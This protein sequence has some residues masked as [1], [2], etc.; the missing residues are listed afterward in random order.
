MHREALVLLK[1]IIMILIQ[2]N[3]GYKLTE[4][5]NIKANPSTEWPTISYFLTQQLFLHSFPLSQT[6]HLLLG[7][8]SH[9]HKI[10]TTPKLLFR[11]AKVLGSLTVCYQSSLCLYSYVV[12]SYKKAWQQMPQKLYLG[13]KDSHNKDPVHQS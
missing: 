1:E 6:N 10:I 5:E 13:D 8:N 2:Q 3:L 4:I 7:S 9:I 12:T 11:Q